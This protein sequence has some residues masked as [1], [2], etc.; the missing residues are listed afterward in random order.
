MHDS[1]VDI[2]E[3][4]GWSGIHQIRPLTEL[5]TVQMAARSYSHKPSLTS[6]DAVRIGQL[7][8]RTWIIKV[9]VR[10]KVKGSWK[11]VGHLSGWSRAYRVLPSLQ[12]QSDL[13]GNNLIHRGLQTSLYF[14]KENTWNQF[15]KHELLKS[16]LTAT[17]HC[18]LSEVWIQ[19][20]PGQNQVYPIEY[21]TKW[22]AKESKTTM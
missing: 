18:P 19:S 12:K 13:V 1:V 22:R 4:S 5:D 2:S 11:C 15:I 14:I 20:T 10:T 9:K 8:I 3:W 6:N 16:T 17:V 21:R 7:S